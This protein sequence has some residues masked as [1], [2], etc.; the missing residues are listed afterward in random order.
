MDIFHIVLFS[1]CIFK[2]AGHFTQKFIY[3]KLRD[4][5][6]KSDAKYLEEKN[7]FQCINHC[8]KKT[9]CE[10]FNFNSKRRTC[11]ITNKR[12]NDSHSD[13]TFTNGWEVY[14][15][16]MK[17]ATPILMEFK[18]NLK[19][20]VK[21]DFTMARVNFSVC[22]WFQYYNKNDRKN[23]TIVRF[24][25]G[26]GCS[27]FTIYLA[28][29][30][31][32]TVIMGNDEEHKIKF[33]FKRDTIYHVCYVHSSDF[34]TWYLDGKVFKKFGSQNYKVGAKHLLIGQHSSDCQ[35]FSGAFEEA[36]LFDLNIFQNSLSPL[37][38]ELVMK[39]GFTVLPIV[40]W[41]SIK[42]SFA[43]VSTVKFKDMHITKLE[44]RCSHNDP[45]LCL[46]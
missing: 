22:F 12:I 2:S 43:N 11:Q 8:Q 45:L 33:G 29:N 16:L 19:V 42:Q 31:F 6:I 20:T 44:D 1:C 30:T 36:V 35:V 4:K 26:N 3:Q 21:M 27:V 23:Y 37:Q 13:V 14:L 5:K 10:I 17:K 9:D 15:Q 41:E 18:S 25:T 32:L 7:L 34:A 38:I 40:S 28:T 46:K 24:V 39:R